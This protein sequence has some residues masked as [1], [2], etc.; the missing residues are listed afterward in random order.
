MCYG[1]KLYVTFA[2]LNIT[3]ANF[4]LEPY[5]HFADYHIHINKYLNSTSS[6]SIRY[7][8]NLEESDYSSLFSLSF[9]MINYMD[10]MK[11]KLFKN[12]EFLEASTQCK[13]TY[14]H[15]LPFSW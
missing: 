15:I 6:I 7:I 4:Q 14:P 1:R 9:H 10:I 3:F 8:H 11:L 2:Y 13:C 12:Q 5:S